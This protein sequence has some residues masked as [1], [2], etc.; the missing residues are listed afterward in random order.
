M[1]GVLLAAHLAAKQR[2]ERLFAQ[3][4][5]FPAHIGN[6][7]KASKSRRWSRKVYYPSVESD[8]KHLAS[9]FRYSYFIIT[10][11]VLKLTK[12]VFGVFCEEFE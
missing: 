7:V 4:C 10:T 5:S 8:P 2:C 12:S 9:S 1:P 3:N 11:M 6:S